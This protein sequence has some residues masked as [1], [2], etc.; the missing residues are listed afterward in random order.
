MPDASG[1]VQAL[2][3]SGRR[4][5]ALVSLRSGPRTPETAVLARE[6]WRAGGNLEKALERDREAGALAA[7]EPLRAAWEA[8][9]RQEADRLRANLAAAGRGN[10]FS[11]GLEKWLED[12][13]FDARTAWVR[14]PEGIVWLREDAGGRLAI[15]SR[16]LTPDR[17]RFARELSRS[18][19]P[20]VLFG[21]GGE[22]AELATIARAEHP[23]MFLTMRR[24]ALVVVPDLAQF[25]MALRVLDLTELLAAPDLYWFAGEDWEETFRHVLA[26]EPMLPVPDP[27]MTLPVVAEP[28]RRVL[29]A[30]S[31]IRRVDADRARDRAWPAYAARS[32]ADW[33]AALAGGA[34]RRT[35]I[36][37]ITSR[38]TT[39]LQYVIRDLATAFE[40]AG[41]DTE[42]VVETDDC[43]RFS[44]PA[45]LRR[46]DAFRPDLAVQLSHIRP[47]LAAFVPPQLPFASWIQD[48]L[49]NLF[50]K[51]FVSQLGANDLVFAMW[52]GMRRD[53][54]AAGYP[55]VTLLSAAANGSVYGAEA[56]ER[57]EYACDVA[58]VSNISPPA[59]E[60]NCP[61]LVERAIDILTSEGIGYRDPPFYRRLL[62]RIASEKGF[63]VPSDEKERTRLV[64]RVLAFD[65]E[66]FVQR[67]QPL[68][69]AREMGLSVGVWGQGWDRIPELASC[70][71]GPVAPGTDLRDLYRS[72][73][74]HLHMNS[75]T[76]VHQRVFECLAAG[77]FLMAWAHPTDGEP[78]GLS[79][80]LAPGR[81]VETFR[82][83]DD[84]REK[85]RA[86]LADDARRRAVSAAGRARV[87]AEHTMER[88]AE[89]ILAAVRARYS[90]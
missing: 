1:S 51:R 25:L 6:I 74:I 85:V 39:V 24:P 36:L 43:Q 73:R 53:C 18:G 76:N 33:R 13:V 47:E 5:E 75:D 86:Y 45:L 16:P 65:V 10:V 55:E 26:H 90:A 23:V 67:T 88:R 11:P 72:A 29:A 77:G 8:E 60:R 54:L 79:G 38:F 30:V 87:L 46:I 62:D 49:P 20:M 71:R 22:W 57:P 63:P 35:R 3:A 2:A 40:S 83:R 34:D 12:P 52:E 70:A 41:C 15:L 81:E 7:G 84:F 59:P 4:A 69:W 64:E 21:K 80:H 68:A 14:E 50:E 19:H 56:R 82:S 48:R 58:F 31:E 27:R 66:R 37:L 17:A 44:G 61:G 78:W 28:V 42:I 89:A 9:R 32:R